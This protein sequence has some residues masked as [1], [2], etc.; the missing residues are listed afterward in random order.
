MALTERVQSI[1]CLRKNEQSD[2]IGAELTFK[3]EV[4]DKIE[5]LRDVIQ[6]ELRDS[7]RSRH[8][9]LIRKDFLEEEPAV[10]LH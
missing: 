5:M 4:K 1:S 10:G 9:G 6:T 2:F 7:K 3:E 8:M